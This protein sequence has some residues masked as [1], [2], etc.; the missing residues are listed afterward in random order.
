MEGI[1]F[2]TMK[3]HKAWVLSVIDEIK[4]QALG[5]CES[6]RDKVTIK[7]VLSN[8]MIDSFITAL[9]ESYMHL[10]EYN[11]QRPVNTSQE[12]L[13]RNYLYCAITGFAIG[14]DIGDCGGYYIPIA[15]VELVKMAENLQKNPMKTREAV[16]DHL[17][18]KYIDYEE[19]EGSTNSFWALMDY[20]F[21]NVGELTEKA[22]GP[23]DPVG[24]DKAGLS[25]IDSRSSDDYIYALYGIP[26]I[27]R[28]RDQLPENNL[29][30]E[31][32]SRF[33]ELYF[34]DKYC[35]TGCIARD[36][37]DMIEAYLFEHGISPLRDL[38]SV[39]LTAS[40]LRR[41]RK[42]MRCEDMR[43]LL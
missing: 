4:D 37:A 39:R 34:D 32:Y 3:R 10:R 2:G 15:Y 7:G 23:D 27:R 40:K 38:E 20:V 14:S 17:T 30:R 16:K 36:I 5:L 43:N 24:E 12:E 21:D 11:G 25:A 29:F 26:Q 33:M 28:W 19:I 6:F 41:T 9:F 18:T 13:Y 8:D 31:K 42:M 35:D 1:Q 22:G